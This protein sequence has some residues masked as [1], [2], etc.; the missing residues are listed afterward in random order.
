VFGE[1]LG[2]P[3]RVLMVVENCP[4]L[5]DPRV[6][7]EAKA[8][9]AAGYRVTV[10]C[11]TQGYPR[12]RAA[13]DIRILEFPM[14]QFTRTIPGYVVEFA[15]AM[16]AIA[17]LSFWALLTGGFDVI[18]VANPP[19]CILPL[20]SVYKLLG[21]TFVYD[22]HDLTPELYVAKFGENGRVSAW[23]LALERYSYRL[24]DHVIVT[25]ESYKELAMQRGS[26]PEAKIT[27]VRNGPDLASNRVAEVD[28]GL[29]SKSP[30]IIAFAGVTGLQDG[31]DGL[32]RA[33]QH[34]RYS[35]H[36]DQFFCVIIGDGAAL[37]ATKVLAH[38]LQ[39]D[40]KMWF[41]GWVSDPEKY[42]SYIAT[43]DICVAPD[44]YNRYNDHSTFVKIMEYMAAGKPIVGFDLRE[45]RRTAESG[46][47]YARP[48]DLEDF[49]TKIAELIAHPERRLSM[50]RLGA[51]RVQ[52]R[53]AWQYSVPNLLNVYQ[54]L[55]QARI[56]AL[57]PPS[58]PP[59]KAPEHTSV[60]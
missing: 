13:G 40:D 9:V 28:P 57:S 17:L 24:A 20:L 42:A 34:L 32:C 5:R 4:Y 53:L 2:K 48:N 41:T 15:Y 55:A 54:S 1:P 58:S 37:A 11:P 19:D 51:S 21:K 27:V 8:L 46:A 6:Q 16:A 3:I 45:T 60:L 30:N 47:L 49:A 12:H 52:T 29:R 22:Q 31:L 36:I 14:W 33:L 44:P 50:G 18:H 35:L 43:A 25:N 59:E 26:V 10:I 38:E 23:L 39:I 56:A 7:R